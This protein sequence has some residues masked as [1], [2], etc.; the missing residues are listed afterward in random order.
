MLTVFLIPTITYLHFYNHESSVIFQVRVFVTSSRPKGRSVVGDGGHLES[1][2][3]VYDYYRKC[4]M[5]LFVVLVH[6][7]LGNEVQRKR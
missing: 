4:T 3:E 6:Y 5:C 1:E 7:R 2:R